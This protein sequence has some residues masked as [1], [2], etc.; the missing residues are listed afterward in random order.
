MKR[1][2]F[3]INNEHTMNRNVKPDI[4]KLITNKRSQFLENID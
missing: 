2:K 1:Y 4:N 3:A